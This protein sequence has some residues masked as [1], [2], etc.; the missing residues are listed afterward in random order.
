[1]SK[2]SAIE[3]A[4]N[5]L[6]ISTINDDKKSLENLFELSIDL[7]DQDDHSSL[8]FCNHSPVPTILVDNHD[9]LDNLSIDENMKYC[10]FE[11]IYAYTLAKWGCIYDATDVSSVQV[12]ENNLYY[13]FK[14]RAKPPIAWIKEMS[15]LY[16]E[17]MFELHTNNEFELWEEFEVVYIDGKEVVFEYIKNQKE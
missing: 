3:W 7:E 2:K 17:M 16:P 5:E 10:G 4:Y 6:T 11:N 12:D 1:M 13:E 8:T 14:T 9:K 15:L